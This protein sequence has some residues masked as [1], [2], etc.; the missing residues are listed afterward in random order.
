M[1]HVVQEVQIVNS[2]IITDLAGS[3]TCLKVYYSALPKYNGVSK[4]KNMEVMDEGH[5]TRNELTDVGIVAFSAVHI[6]HQI[7]KGY[8]KCHRY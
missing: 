8:V 4:L 1:P 3:H 5:Q 2:A 6:I 7:C